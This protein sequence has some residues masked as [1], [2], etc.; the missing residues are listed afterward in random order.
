MNL[1]ELKISSYLMK[2]LS[3][4]D[5]SYEKI[6]KLNLSLKSRTDAY[7]L[8][9]FLN[10]WGCRQFIKDQHNVAASNLIRWYKMNEKKLPKYNIKL[11]NISDK[12]IEGF[13][14][15]FDDLMKIHASTDK[16]CHR[17]SVGPVG[18]AK[19]LFCLRI[20]AFPPWDNPIIDYFGFE[21]NGVDY[22]R[23]LKY[24]KGNILELQNECN[25]LNIELNQ[26]PMILNRPSITLVKLIDEY[27]WLTI[28]RKFDPKKI[29]ELIK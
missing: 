1:Q 20:H 14:P 8:L 5:K 3:F 25:Q 6:C 23:Y 9:T 18:A 15:L 19:A 27:L 17:K 22:C 10:E 11:I 7:I 4:E 28:T 26:I 24:I 13:A 16:R 2:I 21:R 12:S 29:I